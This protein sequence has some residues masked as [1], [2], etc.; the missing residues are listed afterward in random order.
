MEAMAHTAGQ[1]KTLAAHHGT[2]QSLAIAG[3]R[4][5][6]NITVFVS[7]LYSISGGLS[8]LGL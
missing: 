8:T 3:K 7:P 2:K 6:A 1:P 4:N 5:T